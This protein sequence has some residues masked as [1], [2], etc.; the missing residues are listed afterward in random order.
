MKCAH[1]HRSVPQIKASNRVIIIMGK[2][3]YLLSFFCIFSDGRLW[4][5]SSHAA[6]FKERIFE[7]I[8]WALPTLEMSNFKPL[9]HNFVNLALFNGGKL[10]WD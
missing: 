3:R 2:C 4:K 9:V 8:V 7:E 1:F 6:W 5:D 10:G